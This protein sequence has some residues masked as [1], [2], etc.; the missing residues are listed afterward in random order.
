MD[1]KSKQNIIEIF[2]KSALVVSI[3]V[4]LC[5]PLSFW[6]INAKYIGKYDLGL[7]IVFSSVHYLSI[8]TSFIIALFSLISAVI[9]KLTDKGDWRH[10]YHAFLISFVSPIAWLVWL[11]YG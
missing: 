5:M 10:L 2:S 8:I 3:F 6:A 7:A 1:S 11:D 9:Y 4:A